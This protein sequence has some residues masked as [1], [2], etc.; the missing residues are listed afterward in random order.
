MT[1]A[2]WIADIFL[3]SLHLLFDVVCGWIGHTLV[4]IVTFGRIRI[5]WGDSSE[6]ILAEAIGAGFLLGVATLVFT[7]L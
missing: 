4:K 6:S 7:L 1:P 3:S 2:S 5:D